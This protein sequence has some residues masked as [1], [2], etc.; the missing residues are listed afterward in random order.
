MIGE[1]QKINIINSRQFSE[2][3][4]LRQHHIC[5]SSESYDPTAQQVLT[6][7][8]TALTDYRK[9]EKFTDLDSY[10]LSYLDSLLGYIRAFNEILKK[11]RENIDYYKIFSVLG[12]SSVYYPAITQL[13]KNGF[14]DQILP[15]KKISS[16]KMVEI[17]DVR[18]LKVREYAGK[19]RIAEFSY[20]L[21]HDKWTIENIEEHLLWFNSHE[22]SNDRF[23]DYLA[24]YDYYKQTGL[25][26][27]IFID[28]C[29]RQSG[30]P[31]TLKQ[32]KSIMKEDPTIEHILSQTPNFN[33]KS[34][35]FKNEEYFEEYNNLLGNLTL[36]E[37]RINS[38]IKNDDLVNKLDGYDRSKFW[39]TKD[40]AT[41]LATT[42]KFKKADLMARGEKLVNDF[43]QRWWA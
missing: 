21:N 1:E 39:M 24:N 10:I 42:G 26:R 20:S 30:K 34:Y 6:D 28:Y 12:L 31:Y 17:I 19:K 23:K 22:I 3:D 29:E 37:K 9:E 14:L 38:A 36:L 5:F 43:A 40:L 35:G 18:V 8:K 32:L 15:T 7:V 41:H 27:T 25:L 11:T 16:L 2:D 13:Q 33:P 4:L